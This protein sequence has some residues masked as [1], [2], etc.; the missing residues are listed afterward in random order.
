MGVEVDDNFALGRGDFFHAD[1]PIPLQTRPILQA[2]VRYVVDVVRN[3]ARAPPI[4]RVHAQL[5]DVDAPEDELAERLGPV[6]KILQIHSWTSR[7]QLA[8]QHPR[9]NSA[10]GELG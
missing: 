3:D 7:G 10:L 4:E 6:A 9:P 8:A 5:V 1:V 2:V